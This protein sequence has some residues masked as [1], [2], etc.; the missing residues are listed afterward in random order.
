MIIKDPI[1][2][3]IVM[4]VHTRTRTRTHNTSMYMYFYDYRIFPSGSVLMFTV[5]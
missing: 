4:V 5:I 3:I 2:Q 1:V